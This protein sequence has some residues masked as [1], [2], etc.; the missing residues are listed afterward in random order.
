MI[1]VSRTF[2]LLLVAAASA[3]MVTACGGSDDDSLGD[4]AD[5]AY[6]YAGQYYDVG[7]A[8]ADPFDVYITDISVDLATATPRLSNIGFKQVLPAS[9]G[10]SVEIVNP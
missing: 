10:D 1:E 6:K 5:V 2:R 9:G 4:R 3:L 8:N 7:T